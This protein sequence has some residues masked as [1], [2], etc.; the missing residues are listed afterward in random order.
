MNTQPAHTDPMDDL[1]PFVDF[2]NELANLARPIAK[3][4]FGKPVP[5][6]Y[7]ADDSPVTLTDKEIEMA[8][9]SAIRQRYPEH[10]ILG[11][12]TG[13]SNMDADYVWVI[14]PIDGTKA[15]IAGKS[16]FT[17]LIALCYQGGP[18]IGVI[19]QP[20]KEERW[21]GDGSVTLFNG[22]EVQPE[23]C[24][25]L[26]EA[27]LATTSTGY[28]NASNTKAFS[29]LEHATRST[30]LNHDGYFYGM[31]ANG[32]LDIVVDVQLKPYD[33]CAL[34]PVIEGA[35]GVITDWSG[36]PVTLH[37]AGHIIACSNILLHKQVLDLVHN[38]S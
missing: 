20:I 30:L 36:A 37:S 8:I 5:T 38:A 15:F 14:D 2:A 4:Y 31:V 33:F 29:A 32:D 25:K 7:K 19:D 10:G 16:T 9:T 27:M 17:S 34:V 28:F 18:V 1:T 24:D 35:G 21:V 6:D 26:A 13:Q 3:Q 12:E 11:E 23:H 22:K